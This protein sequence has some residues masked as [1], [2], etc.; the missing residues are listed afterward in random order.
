M[1]SHQLQPHET[2]W[3][4]VTSKEEDEEEVGEPV[5][6]GPIPSAYAQFLTERARDLG[7]TDE[8]WAELAGV[9]KMGAWRLRKHGRSVKMARALRKV[10][11]DRGLDIPP[12]PVDVLDWSPPSTNQ[13]REPRAT[14]PEDERVRLNMIRFRE[15]LH[16]TQVAAADRTGIAY[17]KIVAFELGHATPGGTELIR[18]A[19]HYGRDVE[20]FVRVG[21]LGEPDRSKIPLAAAWVD[22]SVS[23]EKRR[24]LQQL[25]D[26][27]NDP[28]FRADKKAMLEHIRNAKKKPP[29]P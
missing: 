29:A 26:E 10:L 28:R 4:R 12:V 8:A 21:D 14:D 27:I 9:H 16:L 24:Q 2:L 13:P 20:D 22:P 25:V 17:E 5:G 23:E 11:V 15:R 18:L 19:K 3:F 6:P 1:S 7:L